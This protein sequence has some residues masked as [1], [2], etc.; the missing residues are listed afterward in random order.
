VRGPR[1]TPAAKNA[2]IGDGARRRHQYRVA[3][4]AGKALAVDLD[5]LELV[6]DPCTNGRAGCLATRP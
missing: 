2:R 1:T 3:H 4:G 5:D 6:P